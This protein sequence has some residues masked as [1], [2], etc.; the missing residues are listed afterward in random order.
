[1]PGR[2]VEFA[3]NG[4]RSQ[5]YLSPPVSGRGPGVVVIQEWWGLAGHIKDVADRFAREGFV[6]LAPDLYHGELTAEPD[7]AGK[8]MMA[9]NVDQAAKDLQGAVAYL[10]GE[11]GASSAKV[12]VIGFCMGGQLALYAAT[13]SPDQVGAVADFYGIHPNV[14]PDLSRLKAPV[15][16]AFA[17]HDDFASPAAARQLEADLRAK[18]IETDFK[19]YPGTEHA[20]FNDEHRMAYDAAAADDAW[21]RAVA[22]FRRHLEE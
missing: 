18:G 10:L 4:G 22:F 1:M 20:F 19:I 8:L 16:G 3:S 11:G 2:M 12:A 7:A 13:V 15:L 6:A 21:G 17:E 5:G 14:H 9:L